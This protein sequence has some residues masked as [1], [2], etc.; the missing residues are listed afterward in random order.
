[1]NHIKYPNYVSIIKIH[2]KNDIL[3]FQH[4]EKNYIIGFQHYKHANLVN[5]NICKDSINKIMLLRHHIEN[6]S[7]EVSNGLKA[8]GS[9][10]SYDNITV[11]LTASLIIPKSPDSE[12]QNV[13]NNFIVSKLA[14]EEFL[15]YPFNKNI[16][17]SLSYELEKENNHFIFTSQVI[18]PCDDIKL[19]REKLHI[20]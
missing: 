16:G 5:E 1:M 7:R 8:I 20:F 15:M 2:N 13:N 4:R 12:I 9:Y 3:G 17:I 11:D 6:V 18:D 19:F 10:E 14:F